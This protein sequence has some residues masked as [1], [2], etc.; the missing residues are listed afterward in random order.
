MGSIQVLL[1]LRPEVLVQEMHGVVD[2]YLQSS[3]RSKTARQLW[4]PDE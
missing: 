1:F 3:S 4:L 2:H